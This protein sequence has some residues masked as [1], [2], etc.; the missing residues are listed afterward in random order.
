[1]LSTLVVSPEELDVTDKMET[2]E[3]LDF[4]KSLWDEFHTVVLS[5]KIWETVEYS[6]VDLT[7]LLEG[8]E[9][10]QVRK[11]DKL[12]KHFDWHNHGDIIWE[13]GPDKTHIVIE[14]A[15]GNQVRISLMD[16]KDIWLLDD[17]QIIYLVES[18]IWLSLDSPEWIAKVNELASKSLAYLK[19]ELLYT[20]EQLKG[21]WSVE[22]NSRQD[23]VKFFKGTKRGNGLRKCVLAKIARSYINAESSII[24]THR[25]KTRKVLEK[26]V[27]WN[28]HNMSTSSSLSYEWFEE[29]KKEFRERGKASFQ[30]SIFYKA[31]VNR[32]GEGYSIEEI[33]FTIEIRE[34]SIES[35]VSKS[36]REKDYENQ[37]DILDLLWISIT[38][39][40]RLEKL[41]VMDFL[42]PLAF[43][44]GEYRVKNKGGITHEEFER[45]LENA[46][47]MVSEDNENFWKLLDESFDKAEKRASTALGYSDVKLVPLHGNGTTLTFELMFLEYDSSNNDGMA[48]HKCFEYKRKIAERIRLENYVS[49]DTVRHISRKLVD[50]IR[51]SDEKE[52]KGKTPVELMREMLVDVIMEQKGRFIPNALWEEK[53][54]EITQMFRGVGKSKI[55]DDVK[56]QRIMDIVQKRK[57]SLSPMLKEVLPSYYLAW[58][59]PFCDSAGRRSKWVPKFTNRVWLENLSVLTRQ[60]RNVRLA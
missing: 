55:P 2:S 21:L 30:G 5:N 47:F 36:I 53:S 60:H 27:L 57:N 22:F 4:L 20:N 11:I 44:Y 56:R 38:T 37:W 7:E 24:Q 49:E 6:V 14:N 16:L 33:D 58:L 54:L 25:N 48:N 35:L 8:E 9:T 3:M 46:D 1:M 31:P 43:K 15:E 17:G 59:L 40:T 28:L 42:A 19:D 45:F 23:I 52:L 50:D 32:E 51:K 41:K 26:K 12:K 10:P 13:I 18:L 39:K 29:G 34:K